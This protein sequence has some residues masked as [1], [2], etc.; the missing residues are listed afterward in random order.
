M[1]VHLVSLRKSYYIQTYQQ[2]EKAVQTNKNTLVTN[3]RH[4]GSI[5]CVYIFKAQLKQRYKA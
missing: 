4:S 3:E 5:Q 1:Y 2:A